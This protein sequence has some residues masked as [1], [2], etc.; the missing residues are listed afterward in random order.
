MST[1][2]RR[3]LALPV[4][5]G[6]VVVALVTPRG[7]EAQR[8]H[9]IAFRGDMG[10]E[11][12]HG[13]PD[14]LFQGNIR[15]EFSVLATPSWL[16]PVHL[17]AGFSWVSFPM[18]PDYPQEQWNYVGSHFALGATFQRWLPIPL[19]L[20]VRVLSVSRDQHEYADGVARQ[21]RERGLRAEADTRDEKIGFKI[22][23]A[24]VMHV[25][26]MLGVGGR[27]GASGEVS[28]RVR[29]GGDRGSMA[30]A[31][32]AQELLDAVAAKS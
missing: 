8:P 32:V 29:H 3:G 7:L 25:P 10:M 4:A 20:E 5:L 12:P 19:Y 18:E 11:V 22:R 16:Y 24:E 23:E 13:D 6:L 27:E 17:G 2:L 26:W 9:F 15:G 21:L 28:V 31:A 30:V 14:R 1:P